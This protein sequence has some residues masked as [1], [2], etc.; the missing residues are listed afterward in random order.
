M[1]TFDIDFAY[2][3]MHTLDELIDQLS[4]HS[5]IKKVDNTIIVRIDSELQGYLKNKT[6]YSDCRMT[7]LLLNCF[8]Y[9][10]ILFT[11]MESVG[12]AADVLLPTDKSLLYLSISNTLNHHASLTGSLGDMQ[13][14]WICK[15]PSEY[16]I[17]SRITNYVETTE[18][19]IGLTIEGMKILSLTDWLHYYQ[20]KV[21]VAI[22]R[23][24]ISNDKYNPDNTFKSSCFSLLDIHRRINGSIPCIAVGPNGLNT[25]VV[26]SI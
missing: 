25:T 26:M 23:Y 14:Q 15:I 2:T 3:T 20:S 21:Y 6:V 5:M 16:V 24:E 12:S 7:A 9:N 1:A 17:Q 13:G 4:K 22:D 11:M 19:Y 10:R 18:Y 8:Y